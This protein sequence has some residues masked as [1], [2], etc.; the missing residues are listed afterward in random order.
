MAEQNALKPSGT[1]S[2]QYKYY[3]YSN[4]FLQRY[5]FYFY[6]QPINPFLRIDRSHES[7]NPNFFANSQMTIPAVTETFRECLVPN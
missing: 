4:I 3:F 1:L 2:L 6:L 7:T 5:C